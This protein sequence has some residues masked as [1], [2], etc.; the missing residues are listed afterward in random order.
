[1]VMMMNHSLSNI[2]QTDDG[3]NETH[4]LVIINKVMKLYQ[5]ICLFIDYNII[6]KSSPQAPQLNSVKQHREPC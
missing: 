5:K 1:M 3:L 2:G 4:V 6:T